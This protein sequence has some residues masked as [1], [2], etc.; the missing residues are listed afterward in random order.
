[1]AR[2]NAREI[3]SSSRLEAFSDGVFAIIITIMVLDLRPP[4]A[5]GI[6]ALLQLWPVVLSYVLSFFV[7]AIYWLNHHRTFHIVKHVG[8]AV[9]WANIVLLFCLS[10]V[11]FFTA[12]MGEHHLNGLSVALYSADMFVC[13]L[14]AMGLRFAMLRENPSDDPAIRAMNR[15]GAR[16]NALSLIFYGA[17]VPLAAVSAALALALVFATA[18]AYVL[19]SVGLRARAEA[20]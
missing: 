6:G 20:T 1:M 2:R 4:A 8:T 13:C 11:P 10:L 18:A 17:A 7:I 14:A 3:T 5:E 12:Y 15:A 19:P 9:L 16:K